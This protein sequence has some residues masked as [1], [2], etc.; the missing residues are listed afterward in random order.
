MA[1]AGGPDYPERVPV[2]A[3][4]VCVDCG[5]TCH[6]LSHLDPEQP[7]EQGDIVA[8]RCEGCGDRWDIVLEEEDEE[9]DQAAT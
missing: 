8:Y 6:L 9:D 1:A 5:S 7:P 2:P 4:I 3:T